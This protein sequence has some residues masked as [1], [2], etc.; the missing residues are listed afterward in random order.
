MKKE[1]ST[2]AIIIVTNEEEWL[3]L[4]RLI[5]NEKLRE[6]IISLHFCSWNK[7]CNGVRTT[8]DMMDGRHFSF[9]VATKSFGVVRRQFMGSPPK[10]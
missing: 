4:L 5:K 1:R 8:K 3:L 10:E 7:S 9:H 6:T 2:S